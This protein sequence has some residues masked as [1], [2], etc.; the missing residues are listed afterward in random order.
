[1]WKILREVQD[2][3]QQLLRSVTEEVDLLQIEVLHM[4][5]QVAWQIPFLY[6]SFPFKTAGG[7][8]YPQKAIARD[9]IWSRLIEN[10]AGEDRAVRA[11]PN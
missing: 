11:R 7:L 8:Q 4:A 3:H 2:D 1:M 9:P 5:P 10:S 6:G